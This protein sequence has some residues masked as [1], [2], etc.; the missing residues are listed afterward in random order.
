M[1]VRNRRLWIGIGTATLAGAVASGAVA[2]EA[3]HPGHKEHANTSEPG[4][5][6]MLAAPQAGEAYLTDGG[7]RDTRIRIYRDIALMRGHLRVG[8]ELIREDRWEDALVHFLH[9][10]EELYGVMERYIKLH[11]VTPFDRELKA[12]AEAVKAKRM[13]AYEQNK[14]VVQR[15]LT[16]ALEKFKT[17]MTPPISSFTVRSAN[18]VL[19]VAGMEYE[20]AIE[21][22]RFVNLME[23]QDAR[24]FVWTA[25]DMYAEVTK[26]LEKIDPAPL[27]EIRELISKMKTAFP[28][29]M[30]PAEPILK[31]EELSELAEK[32]EEL[33][34]VY[35]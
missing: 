5:P 32:V 2:Q 21:D 13:G 9:P 30:P 18:E 4:S 7:P 29:P 25:E 28:A 31:P 23:Y 6:N 26:N 19:K 22:G 35:W 27:K 10:T 16:A 11:G 15:R 20:A 33:S 14:K 34:A 17:F 24:G 12:Q 3:K 1:I 8:D